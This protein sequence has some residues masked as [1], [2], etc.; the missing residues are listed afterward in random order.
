MIIEIF[1]IRDWKLCQDPAAP[2]L[3]QAAVA[4]GG[5]L[6]L[7]IR[8]RQSQQGR[9]SAVREFLLRI[10]GQRVGFDGREPFLPQTR[11]LLSN[12]FPAEL[13]AAVG[14]CEYLRPRTCKRCFGGAVGDGET[15]EFRI[16]GQRL[17]RP[18][19]V[20]VF[21]PS[22]PAFWRPE[23]AERNPHFI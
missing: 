15:Q 10:P 7:S 9:E 12:F 14:A 11:E 2:D 5:G 18:E 21:F 22:I 4:D 17:R 13:I 1:G 16:D 19:G 8:Q 3:K 23:D 20:F 6:P